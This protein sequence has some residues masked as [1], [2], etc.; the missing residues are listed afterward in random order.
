MPRVFDR[1]NA[2][3][4]YASD[5]LAA[6]HRFMTCLAILPRILTRKPQDYPDRD[7]RNVKLGSGRRDSKPRSR[8]LADASYLICR[9]VSGR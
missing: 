7:A 9:G 3:W 2:I 6:M 8:N 4:V 5:I 1:G